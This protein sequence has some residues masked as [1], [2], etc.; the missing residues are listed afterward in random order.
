VNGLPH[1]KGILTYPSQHVYDG[2]FQEGRSHGKGTSYGTI[3]TGARKGP[4]KYEGFWLE[5]MM[6]GRG[7]F[8]F[9][10]GDV[11]DGDWSKDKPNGT[12]MYTFKESGSRYVGQM[13]DGE[14]HGF[15]TFVHK[16]G[17]KYEGEWR[18]DTRTGK[19][20][21]IFT[22]SNKYEGYWLRGHK[23]GPGMLVFNI[24]Q[25]RSVSSSYVQ[26]TTYQ[27]KSASSK[28]KRKS[29]IK[30]AKKTISQTF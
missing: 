10:N 2:E 27:P 18:H 6:A 21:E 8:T 26:F 20:V 23:H 15:G 16:D 19:G 3:T 5:D 22:N 13:K 30:S 28:H 14:R 9:P 25:F 17:T 29:F 7:K 24:L 4:F 11:Y 1:G 12:G